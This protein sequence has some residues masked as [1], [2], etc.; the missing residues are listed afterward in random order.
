MEKIIRKTL[1]NADSTKRAYYRLITEEI[2]GG[3]II[4]KESGCEGRALH[5]ETYFRESLVEA[6]ELHAK[7][8]KEK[9]NKKSKRKR[10]YYIVSDSDN[11]AKYLN[12]R[13][14]AVSA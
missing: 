11:T 12:Q 5:K 9:T 10:I 3:F 4:K 6:R 14:T 8:I 13:I 7:K 1:L 2:N